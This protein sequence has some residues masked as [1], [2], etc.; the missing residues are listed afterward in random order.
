VFRELLAETP[1]NPELHVSMAHALK[2]LAGSRGDR[3]LSRAAKVRPS[4]GDAYWSLAN[5]KTYRFTDEEIAR[6][7][8][9]ETGRGP[10]CS[11]GT[12]CVL[13][14]ARRWRIERIRRILPLL[15]A[16]QR[17]QKD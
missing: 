16:G 11:T 5:L 13:P 6:M 7:R 8:A 10:G 3:F 9:Q 15:R 4:F 2:T 14:W 1:Q 12:T 17:A